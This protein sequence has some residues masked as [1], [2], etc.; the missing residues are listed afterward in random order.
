MF[1][2]LEEPGRN[3]T[4]DMIDDPDCVVIK[5]QD[6]SSTVLG[7]VIRGPYSILYS[8]HQYESGFLSDY[9]IKLP[10]SGIGEPMHH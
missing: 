3:Y 1:G 6:G 10:Y 2:Q 5:R 9:Q 8:V 4:L 7:F